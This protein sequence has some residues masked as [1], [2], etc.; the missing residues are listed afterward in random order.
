MSLPGWQQRGMA[1]DCWGVSLP[2]QQV[3]RVAGCVFVCGGGGGGTNEWERLMVG[4]SHAA[5]KGAALA[6]QCQ[7]RQ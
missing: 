4:R 1:T 2:G 3:L 7:D 6:L 5:A